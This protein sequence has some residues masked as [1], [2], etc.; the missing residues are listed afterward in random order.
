M[1]SRPIDQRETDAPP[2]PRF[3]PLCARA[4]AD[5][6]DL[7]GVCGERLQPQGFCGVCD[8]FWP[9]PAGAYCPKHEI[10]LEETM[11]P[12][13]A[14]MAGG[15]WTTVQV[16]TDALAAGGPRTRLEAEGIPTFL[17]GERMGMNSMY[18]IATGGVR[19]QVPEALVADARVI[20]AQ[21]WL[22]PDDDLD[23]AWDELAPEPGA[24]WRALV[25]QINLVMMIAPLVLLGLFV[26]AVA[27]GWIR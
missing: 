23:D 11:P 10:P 24:G 26:A 5:E 17:E 7:C 18:H 2:A 1:S 3:C 20:L 4:R 6:G 15:P 8:H 27:L 12:A 19:L 22:P 25:Y 21:T 13:P 14:E 16:Y 9:R